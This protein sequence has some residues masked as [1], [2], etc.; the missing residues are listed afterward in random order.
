[1]SIIT[2]TLD[3][4]NFKLSC[5]EDSKKQIELLAEKLDY[6]IEDTKKNNPAASFE[7]ALVITALGL[8]NDKLSKSEET[9]GDVLKNANSDFQKLLTSV[10]S[11]LNLVAEKL[12]KC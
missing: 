5:S 6:A 1:M 8:I 12:E 10:F 11:E 2:I 3:N 4:K 9:A 7:L